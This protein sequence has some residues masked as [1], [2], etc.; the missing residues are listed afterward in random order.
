MTPPASDIRSL[1]ARARDTS[2]RSDDRHEAFGCLVRRFQH[3]VFA[4]AHARL[5]DRAL[6]EDA[7]QDAFLVA[8]QRL[9]QLREPDAFPGWILRLVYTQCNR[10]LRAERLHV[11]LEE[12]DR[13]A[14]DEDASREDRD[15]ARAL[16]SR[17]LEGLRPGDRLVLSL[18]YGAECSHREIAAWLGVPST[19]IA[20]RLAHAKRRLHAHAIEILAGQLRDEHLRIAETL[21]INV[22]DT[23][24][25]V[26]PGDATAVSELT[27]AHEF[28]RAHRLP[29]AD[30]ACAY[31]AVD[32][33]TQVPIAYVAALPTAFRP[34][35]ELQFAAGPSVV[36]RH[37]A[38]ALLINVVRDLTALRAVSLQYRLSIERGEVLSFLRSRGFDRVACVQ[39]WRLDVRA[40]RV[41]D[42]AHTLRPPTA[43]EPLDALSDPALFAQALEVAASAIAEH[44][45][46]A[47]VLPIH[48]DT[49]R[50][51]IRAQHHGLVALDA[52][53]LV[54]ILGATA[55]PVIP[56]TW[57]LNLVAVAPRRRRQ[58]VA[59]SMLRELL[60]RKPASRMRCVA[61]PAAGL[62]AWLAACEFV[63]ADEEV[64]L[65]RLLRETVVVPPETLDDYVGEYV[66]TGSNRPMPPITIE[67][68]G[69]ALVSKARDMRDLL[70]AASET[71]FFARHHDGR[72]R[73]ER[74]SSGRIE[75]LIF[76]D[77]GREFV[78]WR[79]A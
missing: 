60:S 12:A 45:H 6:A 54:G 42:A 22:A 21:S 72:G 65:E 66:V 35:Y 25:R 29:G 8:W 62:D 57:R 69:R 61:A 53:A 7:A 5:R 2:R 73:F 49:L 40:A 43:F 4:A 67:R 74:G 30:P 18:F 1:I 38:D 64:L 33:A 13:I 17:A 11:A 39:D 15:H 75:R 70:L 34:I 51:V 79:R 71:E 55:D 76:T 31:V 48:P 14:N 78:A 44:P 58:G 37:V 36:R 26:Q 3:L 56:D 32:P 28:D 41:A 77:S 16:V 27:V 59:T 23:I 63:L 68:H 46:A 50:R 20:R 19:T 47:V 24:R 52:G 9:E 10:R